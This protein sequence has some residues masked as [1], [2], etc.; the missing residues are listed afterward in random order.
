MNNISKTVGWADIGLNPYPGCWGPGGTSEKPKWCPYCYARR[1]AERFRG[2]AAWPNGFDPT[3]RLDRLEEL[4]HIRK[5]RKIFMGDAGDLLADWVPSEDIRCI[6]GATKIFRSHTYLWLTKN[7]ARYAEFS[8]WPSNCWLGAT[9]TTAKQFQ[10]ALGALYLVRAPVRFLSIEP[11]LEEVP[12]SLLWH[13][14]RRRLEWLIVGCETGRR[15]GKVTLELG[16][17]L[18]IERFAE[19]A[20]ILVWE[21]GSREMRALLGRPLRQE[22]P[23]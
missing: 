10:V 6:I 12:P 8:P 17:I 18:D 2:T 5:P 13:L 16:W 4:G 3:P 11:L 23:G 15:Q 19:A 7:P 21:K 14:D 22:R 1:I 20:N 9:A